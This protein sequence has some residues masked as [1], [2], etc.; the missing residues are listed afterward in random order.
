M[1]SRGAPSSSVSAELAWQRRMVRP[2][3]AAVPRPHPA[4]ASPPRQKQA[5]SPNASPQASGLSAAGDWEEVAVA[6]PG[7]LPLA[8][9]KIVALQRDPFMTWLN[10]DGQEVVQ[11]QAMA[12]HVICSLLRRGCDEILYI[13]C[14]RCPAAEV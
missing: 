2:L 10:R 6:F 14:G 12:R 13:F 4:L 8:H 7:I 11:H 3:A 9:N 5:S 1:E